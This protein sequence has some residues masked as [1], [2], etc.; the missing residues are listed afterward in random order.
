MGRLQPLSAKLGEVKFRRKLVKQQL[1]KK[2]LIPEEPNQK[3]ITKILKERVKTT[4]K[5][6]KNFKTR[7]FPLSPFLEIGAEK[8]QRSMLL[9]NEFGAKGF[10][11]DLS[12]ESLA[13]A[14]S[15]AKSLSF[16]N[17]PTLLCCDA[18]N[19][20]FA[21]NSFPFIFCFE[22]LHHFPDPTLVTEEI[23]RVLSPGGVFYF[24]EEPVKQDINL[25]LWRRGYHLSPQEK[26]LKAI[27]I[28]PFLSKIG[29]AEVRHGVL[30]EEFSL[31]LW[32]KALSIF[33]KVETTVKPVFFGPG[34]SL[35]KTQGV[36]Q[37]PK[38]ITQA[39]I[40]LQGGGIEGFG[41]KKGK[42][43][44]QKDL[45]KVLTCPDCKKKLVRKRKEL[46]CPACQ[47]QFS[48]K[49]GVLMLLPI[50]LQKK[51]YG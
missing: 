8:G 29:K 20:P 35:I 39:L 51:L 37:D 15:F 40:S 3:E 10:A 17:L 7:G 31:K 5:I 41:I 19:L 26:F 4:R 14:S 38:L 28:L 1:G 9:V 45:K 13:A 36:W 11:S 12:F 50:K 30:E 34:G 27:G 24:G 18:Y 16:K 47:R 2:G 6:F 23:Y 42:P 48:K 25:N 44:S 22:T 21:N 46:S 43:K 32:K 49:R 33:Y